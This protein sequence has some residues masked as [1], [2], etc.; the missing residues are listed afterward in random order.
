M[1]L[2]V[3]CAELEVK[4]STSHVQYPPKARHETAQPNIGGWHTS[5][6][7]YFNVSEDSTAPAWRW[8]ERRLLPSL[9][10]VP[11]DDFLPPRRM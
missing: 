10:M 11:V 8:S 2:C 6:G 9:L 4:T 3:L 7:Q 5:A 1:T